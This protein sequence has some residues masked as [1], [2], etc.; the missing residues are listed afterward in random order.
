MFIVKKSLKIPKGSSVA[1]NWRR[2]DKTTTKE[3]KTKNDLQNTTQKTKVRPTLT[4]LKTGGELGCPVRVDSSCSTC[5]TRRVTLFTNKWCIY[6]DNE[7][8]M[9]GECQKKKISMLIL[10]YKCMYFFTKISKLQKGRNSLKVIFKL[11][12]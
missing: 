12:N 1:V 8:N 11:I 9:C 10:N 2:T 7:L 4:T 5:G 3:K 6:N